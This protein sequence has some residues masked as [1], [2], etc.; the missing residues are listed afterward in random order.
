[1]YETMIELWIGISIR[2]MAST[3]RLWLL[4][5]SCASCR[6]AVSLTVLSFELDVLSTEVS[7]MLSTRQVFS[8]ASSSHA[9]LLG[10]VDSC[11][12]VFD[13]THVANH[14]P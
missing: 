7:V 10:R 2:L 5:L 6:T 13:Y 9:S 8:A 1:M 12:S 11:D 4:S 3:I 14:L